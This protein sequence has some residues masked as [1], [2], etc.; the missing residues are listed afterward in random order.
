MITQK[1]QETQK[2]ILD[3]TLKEV[4]NEEPNETQKYFIQKAADILEVAKE[5]ESD[6]KESDADVL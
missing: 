6:E 1:T 4:G 5:Q 2:Q 3:Q